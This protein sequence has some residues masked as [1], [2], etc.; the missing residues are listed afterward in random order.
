MKI[1]IYGDSIL[2]GVRLENGRYTID[3]GWEQRM[4]AEH[5]LDIRNSAHFGSTLGKGLGLI[6]RDSEKA[7][8]ADE[9]AVLE[10]GGNDC[11][12][13]WAAIAADPQGS[14]ACKTPPALFCE[15]YH[16]AVRL[17]RRSGRRPVILTLPPIHSLRYLGFICRDGLSRENIL[18]WLGDVNAIYRW[19]A[20]YSGMAAQ[21]A[22]EEGA[23][24]I[25]LRR[26]FLRDGRSP[27]E[28]LCL[29]GIHPSRAGQGIIYDTLAAALT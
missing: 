28:L 11:D 18:R 26:A 22:R 4:A 25:D 24:L 19:Q 14:F 16:E 10:F 6:L 1:T 20:Q 3:R 13:D 29:D 12:Y 27:E 17:I 23:E 5:D 15:L 7:Y 9:L 2:K 8:D 21:I